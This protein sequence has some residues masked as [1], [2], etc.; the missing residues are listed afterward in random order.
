MMFKKLFK[1]LSSFQ[2]AVIVIV[3]LAVSQGVATFIE[4]AQSTRAAQYWVYQTY[5]FY[6]I[7]G[8][9]G[10]SIAC[11]ALSRFPWKKRHGPFLMAHV[12]I[13]T[14][15]FGSFLTYQYGIDASLMVSEGQ[16]E[17]RIEFQ[18]ATFSVTDG[19]TMKTIPVGWVPSGVRFAPVDLPEFEVRLAGFITHAEPKFQFKEAPADY[20]G[21]IAPAIH[22]RLKGGP[23]PFAR[24]F[25]LWAG[26]PDWASVPLGPAVFHIMPGWMEAQPLEKDQFG[27]LMGRF[28]FQPNTDQSLSYL[29]QTRKGALKKGKLKPEEIKDGMIEPGWMGLQVTIKDYIIRAMNDTQ[30]VPSRNQKGNEAAPSAL[31][32]EVNGEQVWL[33]EGDRARITTEDGKMLQM[34]YTRRQLAL[35]F[36]IQLERFNIQHYEGTANPASFESEVKVVDPDAKDEKITISMNEP[37]HWK[38]I[39]FYQSSYIP[40]SPRPTTSIFSVNRDPGRIWKYLGSLLIVLGSIWLFAAK[41]LGKK[42]KVVKV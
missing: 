4:S 9:L 19:K 34:V 20:T 17:N 41:Y 28:L 35:P 12:G 36:S 29:S 5:W 10:V 37:L 13:L 1:F 25:W 39:T 16:K 23:L 14:L 24:E 42:K 30:Y 18:D 15:L 11:V 32:A 40:E 38:G 21:K 8:L 2:M 6:G 33:G 31:M 27:S 26:S 3:L 7:L 22:F